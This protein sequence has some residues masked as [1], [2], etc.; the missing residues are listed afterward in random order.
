MSRT[1]ELQALLS[2]FTRCGPVPAPAVQH[3]IALYAARRTY[4]RYYLSPSY[5]AHNGAYWAGVVHGCVV[6]L[7]R[8]WVMGR[9]VLYAVLPPMSI[10]PYV[11]VLTERQAARNLLDLGIGIKYGEEDLEHALIPGTPVLQRGN[12]EYIY[13]LREVEECSGRKYARVR[14]ARNAFRRLVDTD[15]LQ[16]FSANTGH[17]IIQKDIIDLT[18][19]WTSTRKRW[20]GAVKQAEAAL[21]GESN[22]SVFYEGKGEPFGKRLIA[23]SLSERIT[24][25]WYIGALSLRT[26]SP[27]LDFLRCSDVVFWHDAI[28]A[29]AYSGAALYPGDMPLYYNFGS[30]V[31]SPGLTAHK[32]ELGPIKKLQIYD[33][34]PKVPVTAEEWKAAIPGDKQLALI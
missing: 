8:K 4:P 20:S 21:A 25:S 5:L 3:A 31:S 14:S 32:E 9:P 17:S 22:V 27:D 23:Y 29:V 1:E 30:A 10:S 2:G 11:E 26:P 18:T 6:L 12:T 7:K 19:E 13:D 28:I 24:P 34:K 33:V 15:N 16:L